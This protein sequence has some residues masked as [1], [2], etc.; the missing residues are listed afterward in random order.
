V[1]QLCLHQCVGGGP[2]SNREV[3]HKLDR[4]HEIGF[5]LNA[6]IHIAQKKEAARAAS[7]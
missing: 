4:G 1:R 2:F 3:S 6:S 5:P 7:R